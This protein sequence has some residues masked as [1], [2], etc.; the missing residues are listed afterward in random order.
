[1]VNKQ[2]DK[3]FKFLL[4][5][6]L[7]ALGL[8]RLPGACE[9]KYPYVSTNPAPTTNITFRDRVFVLCQNNIARDLVV[10]NNREEEMFDF[11]GDT[12]NTAPSLG[13]NKASQSQLGGNKGMNSGKINDDKGGSQGLMEFKRRKSS[14]TGNTSLDFYGSK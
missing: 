8:Y 1:M 12:M 10:D 2:F 5:K 3:L 14:W 7:V 13:N 4:E 6:N 9:N 11:G